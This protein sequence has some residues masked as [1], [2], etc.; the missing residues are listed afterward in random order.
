MMQTGTKNYKK[1]LKTDADTRVDRCPLLSLSIKLNSVLISL[2]VM[3]SSS[4]DPTFFQPFSATSNITT[5]ERLVS[6]LVSNLKLLKIDASVATFVQIVENFFYVFLRDIVSDAL[7]VEDDLVDGEGLAAV[8][9]DA[10]EHVVQLLL[11]NLV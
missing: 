2:S 11:L 4:S 9:V 3:P 1:A 6:L 8:G 5:W 10:A 7:E